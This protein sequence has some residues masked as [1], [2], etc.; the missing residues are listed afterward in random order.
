MIENPHIRAMLKEL[1]VAIGEEIKPKPGPQDHRDTS[2]FHCKSQSIT[3]IDIRKRQEEAV[4]RARAQHAAE[5]ARPLIDATLVTDAER[6]EI[7]SRVK[8][9]THWRG[10]MFSGGAG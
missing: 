2:P 5:L 4:R 3:D 10:I 7:R 8:G 6:A 1:D 9:A